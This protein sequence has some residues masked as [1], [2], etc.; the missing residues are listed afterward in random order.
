MPYDVY[1]NDVK[2]RGDFHL[3][4]ETVNGIVLFA[5][6][7]NQPLR[8]VNRQWQSTYRLRTKDPGFTRGQ[9]NQQSQY[10]LVVPGQRPIYFSDLNILHGWLIAQHWLNHPGV[11]QIYRLIGSTFYPK[12]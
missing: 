6:A 2:Y 1:I 10:A 11:Y 5:E 7:F 4:R 8:F 9:P 12:P 3:D